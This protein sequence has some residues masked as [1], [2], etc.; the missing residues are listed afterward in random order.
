MGTSGF[1]LTFLTVLSQTETLSRWN[2]PLASR[3][4]SF[5]SWIQSKLSEEDDLVA[6]SPLLPAAA[7]PSL[8]SGDIIG[9]K[10][11]FDELVVNGKGYHKKTQ[12]YILLRLARLSLCQRQMYFGLN[13]GPL[14]MSVLCNIFLG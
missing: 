10:N 4:N 2:C 11:N 9:N 8:A 6:P 13:V 7:A 1:S 12:L 5:L 14:L 3:S